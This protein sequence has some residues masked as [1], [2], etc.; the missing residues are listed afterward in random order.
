MAFAQTAGGAQTP[1]WSKNAQRAVTGKWV[2]R[3]GQ[4]IPVELSGPAGRLTIEK[5]ERPPVAVGP[6]FRAGPSLPHGSPSPKWQALRSRPAVGTYPAV[7]T[8]LRP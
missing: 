1:A 4:S 2:R 3:P 8:Q 6:A 5:A 7:R